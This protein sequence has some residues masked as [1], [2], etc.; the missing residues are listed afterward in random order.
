MKVLGISFSPRA[1]N[2]QTLVEHILK[3][4]QDAGAE[5]ELIRFCDLQVKNCKGCGFCKM[6][7]NSTCSIKDDMAELYKKIGSADAVVLGAPVYFGRM[8][9]PA[10]TFI[11]RFY[12]MLNP[13]FSLR[14]S[15]GKKMAVAVTCGSGPAEDI[16]KINGYL[17]AIGGYFGWT[18]KG[19]IYERN[20]MEKDAILKCADKLKEAEKLGKALTE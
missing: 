13:D 20:L 17:T 5:T 18:N 15:G 2:S 10:Y 12:A 16:E 11:D 9:S 4:A 1:G 3:G 7:G 8:N 14:I 6:P 19:L